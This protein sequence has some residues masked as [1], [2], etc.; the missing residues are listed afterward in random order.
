MGVKRYFI[1]ILNT[2]F[3]TVII[4][5]S[6]VYSLLIERTYKSVMIPLISLTVSLLKV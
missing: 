2:K 1:F 6:C 3:E 5:I 4:F